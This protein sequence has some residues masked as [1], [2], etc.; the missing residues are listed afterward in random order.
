MLVRKLSDRL[1]YEKNFGQPFD[2][3]GKEAM[4]GEIDTNL[5]QRLLMNVLT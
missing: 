4:K 5:L 2:N 3:L 1:F